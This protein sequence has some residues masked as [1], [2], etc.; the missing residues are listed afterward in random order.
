M[1]DFCWFYFCL[2]GFFLLGLLVLVLI[3]FFLCI[4]ASWQEVSGYLGEKVSQCRLILT[5]SSISLLSVCKHIFQGL[6]IGKFN[7]QKYEKNCFKVLM[8]PK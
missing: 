4:A 7:F 5:K 2:S 6:K 3:F 8:Q 1:G